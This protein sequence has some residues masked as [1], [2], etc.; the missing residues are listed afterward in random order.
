MKLLIIG[1]GLQGKAAAEAMLLSGEWQ[2]TAFVDGCWPVLHETF[3]GPMVSGFAELVGRDIQ[4]AGAIA[5]RS[6]IRLVCH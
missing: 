6:L 5:L 1:V 2:R 3:G 4:I